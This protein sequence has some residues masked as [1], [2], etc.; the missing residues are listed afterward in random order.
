VTDQ[1]HADH[2]HTDRSHT[3]HSQTGG[4]QDDVDGGGPQVDPDDVEVHLVPLRRRH[5]R[6]VMRIEDQVYPHPWSLTLFMSELNLRT[7]RA[8]VAARVDGEVVGYAGLMFTG[9]ES[10]V[11]TIAVDPRWHRHKIGSRMLSHLTRVSRER[12]VRH[13]TLEVRVANAGAQAMY[14]KFGFE[15]AGIR[16]NYYAETKEDALIMWVHD[17]DSDAHLARLLAIEAG[18]PGSTIVED[19]RR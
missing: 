16:K 3:D 2:S 12:N 8:Y 10:H 17:I 4:R 19:G 6:S 11:T 7:T 5:L 1:D 15:P 9:D 13:M 18:I 14:R